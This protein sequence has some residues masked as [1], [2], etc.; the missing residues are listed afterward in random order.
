MFVLYHSHGKLILY[1]WSYSKTAKPP[2]NIN[3]LLSMAK[4]AADA[5]ESASGKARYQVGRVPGF[6]NEASCL[7]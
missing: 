2:K 7:N 3:E 5:M 6:F 4:T 1:P